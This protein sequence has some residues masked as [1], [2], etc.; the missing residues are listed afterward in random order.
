[1][2][3]QGLLRRRGMPLAL[4]D[5]RHPIFKHKSEYQPVGTP[6]Q[7]GGA[8]EELGIQ[9]IFV[10]SPQAKGRVERPVGTSQDRLVAELR[11]AGATTIDKANFVLQEF[12]PRFNDGFSVAAEQRETA[13]RPDCP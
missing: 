10:L 8:I 3:M 7:F 6:I 2:L 5:D 11:L 12:R 13:C 9:L 1:M 4:Y